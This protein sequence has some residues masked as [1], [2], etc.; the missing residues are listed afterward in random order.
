M[1][2]LISPSIPNRFSRLGPRV[3]ARLQK[4]R[5]QRIPGH[6]QAVWEVWSFQSAGSSPPV[7]FTRPVSRRHLALLNVEAVH[8]VSREEHSYHMLGL[9]PQ[10]K[11]DLD[12]SCFTPDSQTTQ[13]K[14][15]EANK[16]TS[17]IRYDGTDKIAASVSK[18]MA[19]RTYNV[20]LVLLNG[21]LWQ[22]CPSPQWRPQLTLKPAL[23]SLRFHWLMLSMSAA[24]DTKCRTVQVSQRCQRG[25]SPQSRAATSWRPAKIST[26]SH[27]SRLHNH[28]NTKAVSSCLWPRVR[29]QRSGSWPPLRRA[30]ALL[31][32][33]KTAIF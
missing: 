20:G 6:S 12:P 13:L 8:A 1:N 17:F 2:V 32:C 19:T 16:T 22:R 28:T 11:R 18:T 15:T 14:P 3:A 29:G 7:V 31:L 23:S 26:T 10:S 33:R 25:D 24:R 27:C 5:L 30:L 21:P 4:L 9:R